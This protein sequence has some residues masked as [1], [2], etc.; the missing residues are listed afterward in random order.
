MPS[1]DS[2]LSGRVVEV[3]VAPGDQVSPGTVVATIESMKMEIPLEA[4]TSGVVTEVLVAAGDDISE[5]QP[6]VTL[7]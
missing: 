7:G 2:N 1:I 3:H 5:G 6:A 4:E